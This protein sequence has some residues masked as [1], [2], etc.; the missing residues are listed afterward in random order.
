MSSVARHPALVPWGILGLPF[1]HWWPPRAGSAILEGMSTD[2]PTDPWDGIVDDPPAVIAERIVAD[3]A[4]RAAAIR[5]RFRCREGEEV[6]AI[7]EARAA[8]DAVELRSM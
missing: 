2:P 7:I 1:R 3:A 4:K 5:Q 8:A 6:A